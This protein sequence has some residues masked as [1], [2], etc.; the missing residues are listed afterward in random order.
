MQILGVRIW[1][2][3][4]LDRKHSHLRR[5]VFKV[6]VKGRKN[7]L[8]EKETTVVKIQSFYGKISAIK[9]H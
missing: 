7:D 4:I 2:K 8:H 1:I 5:K 9:V 3:S 6:V